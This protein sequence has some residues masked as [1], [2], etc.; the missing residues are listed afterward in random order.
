MLIHSLRLLVLVFVVI[1]FGWTRC[2]DYL[3]IPNTQKVSKIEFSFVK[4]IE[5]YQ[6]QRTGVKL[7]HERPATDFVTVT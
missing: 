2:E 6:H 5:F 3:V 7:R 1:K 4:A